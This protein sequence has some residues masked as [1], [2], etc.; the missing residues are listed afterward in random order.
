[1][2]CNKLSPRFFFFCSVIVVIQ[3]FSEKISFRIMADSG[4][5]FI[6]DYP[7]AATTE[8]ELSLEINDKIF[9]VSKEGDWI[10][11]YKE[12]R[13]QRQEGWVAGSYGHFRQNSPYANIDDRS[14]LNQR[15]AAFQALI[16]SEQTFIK[17]LQDLKNTLIDVMSIRDDS[18]KRNFMNEPSVAVSFTILIDMLKACGNFASLLSGCRDESSVTLAFIQFSPSMQLFAQYATENIKLLNAVKTSSKGLK[19]LLPKDFQLEALLVAPTQHYPKYKNSMQEYVWLTP[20]SVTGK[21]REELESAMDKVIG[22]SDY[23]DL[24]LK[25]ETEALRLLALQ[26]TFTGHPAIFT[27]TRRILCEFEIERVRVKPNNELET[28][29]FQAHL[30]ND[31]FI[32][33]SY[34]VTRKL[35]LQQM[36]DLRNARIDR[37]S[38]GGTSTGFV[39]FMNDDDT[40]GEHFRVQDAKEFEDFMIQVTTQMEAS[41]ANRTEVRTATIARRGTVLGGNFLPG[42]QLNDLQPRGSEIYRFLIGEM[43]FAEAVATLNLVM[44]EPLLN[45]AKGAVLRA[46][47]GANSLTMENSTSKY[48]VGL[49]T[50]A[51]KE[52]DV[53]LCLRSVEGLT[54]SCKEF[55][56]AMEKACK[57]SNW[58]ENIMI[59]EVFRSVSAQ[60]LYHQF[61]SYISGQQALLRVLR[62]APF[63]QF[64]KDCEQ[65]LSSAPGTLEEKLDQPRQR[66]KLFGTFLNNVL[67][68]TPTPHADH[69]QLQQSIVVIDN[70]DKEITELLRIKK[71]FEHLLEIQNSLV[72]I[73]N[74]PIIQKLASMERTFIRQGD[75]KKVCRKKNKLFRFWLV[76]DYLIY[77]SSLGGDKYSFNRAMELHKVSVAAHNGVSDAGEQ[78]R[79]AFAILGAE[80][81]FIVIAPTAASC[82]EWID[83]ISKACFAAREARGLSGNATD[84]APVWQADAASDSCT[85]CQKKFT[86]WNRK[87]HCRKCGALVCSDH[88][89]NREILPHISATMKQ[90][91]CDNCVKGLTIAPAVP[92]RAPAVANS[93]PAAAATTPT[94]SPAP[95]SGGLASLWKG[96]TAN[97]NPTAASSTSATSATSSPAKP[98]P[99]PTPAPAPTS[100]TTTSAPAPKPVSASTQ[101]SVT[102][103]PPLAATTS[104]T[105]GGGTAVSNPLKSAASANNNSPSDGMDS[106]KQGSVRAMIAS[107]NTPSSTPSASTEAPKRVTNSR[108]GASIASKFSTRA[109]IVRHAPPPPEEPE[110]S[111]PTSPPP[112]LPT[113]PPPPIPE[114][115]PAP[116]ASVPPPKRV[117]APPPAEA[118]AAPSPVPTAAPPVPGGGAKGP[119]PPPPRSTV[120]APPPPPPKPPAP[121]NRVNPPAQSVPPPVAPPAAETSE[122]PAEDDP[123]RRFLKMK[124]LMPPDA[125]RQKMKLAGFMEQDVERFLSGEVSRL[126][127]P[128]DS[129]GGSIGAVDTASLL[130]SASLRPPPASEPKPPAAAGGMMSL[131]GEIQRGQKLKAVQA[132]D[133]RMKPTATAAQATDMLS[134]LAMKM[135]E[136]RFKMGSAGQAGSDSDS[137]SSGFSDSDS[138]SD[139]D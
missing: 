35:K 42:V 25:E 41:R 100:T 58:S 55:V 54:V 105:A 124:D 45:A 85:Q 53:L 51:L 118:P 104:S 27:P 75:L 71:N 17:E 99:A 62:T 37:S 8:T 109:S 96:M 36:A 117:V 31:C 56:G 59:G 24:K 38:I 6:A 120:G 128:G 19:K 103:T 3:F 101:A 76:S 69:S 121:G 106:I 9:V 2:I 138:D 65:I 111:A 84:S 47:D 68:L 7:Y 93:T 48:Q 131:L 1:L 107:K 22:Q 40:T 39:L 88:L 14:K 67:R 92:T 33:S 63:A 80:K 28:K 79:N 29:P 108:A 126:P 97:A 23:I 73:G 77:A 57:A 95:S 26:N 123:F 137:D 66:I 43:Q 12:V 94:T 13:G 127:M 32:I 61:K 114:T 102:R 115:A 135:T 113:S 5:V 4:E 34:T 91:I 18:F 50:E 46:N 89:K 16:D 134:M 60:T 74:E 11:G 119:P 98:V 20:S 112:P 125:V 44:V 81:S 133:S 136:R 64:Y 110:P 10:Y 72:T 49:V 52:A 21:V 129:Q 130:S 90:K 87:H 132:D 86:L 139:D 78:L 30:F 82:E 116:S 122:V 83:V 70:M 15:T